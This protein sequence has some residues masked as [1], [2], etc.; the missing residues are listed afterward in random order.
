MDVIGYALAKQ[1][2]TL[3]DKLSSL[4]GWLAD[5][6]VG[7]ALANNIQVEEG[8]VWEEREPIP[9]ARR[10]LAS[11]VI[12]DVLYAVGGHIGTTSATDKNEAYNPSTNTWSTKATMPTARHSLTA[13]VID[14]VLYAVG[15]D[16][17]GTRNENEAYN[18]TDKITGLEPLLGWLAAK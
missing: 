1:V 16:Y 13:G 4:K 11:G 10:Y 17:N 18:P 15:G 9:T 8:D 7:Y 14:G 2:E 5:D 6:S 3:P 12:D